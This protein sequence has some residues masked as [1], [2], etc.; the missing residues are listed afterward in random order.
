M[1]AAEPIRATVPVVIM[2][3]ET[4]TPADDALPTADAPRSQAQWS[5]SEVA[6]DLG[7]SPS[8][9]RTWIAYMSWEVTRNAEGHRVFTDEDVQ[10]LRNLKAWLDAGNSMKEF[11]RERQGEGPYDPRLELRNGVRR[12]RELQTQ[13]DAMITKHRE[14]LDGYLAARRDLQDRLEN[15]R[16]EVEVEPGAPAAAAPAVPAAPTAS[17]SEV[18]QG[19]LKQLLSALLEKQG[20]L[21]LAGRLEEGGRTYIEYAAPGGR[22]QIVEDLCATEADRKLL[23]TVLSII[24]AGHG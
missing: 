21:Q 24:L 8:L 9:V 22:K 15:L 10:Q 4:P 14:M 2:M 19:V 7:V 23:D 3:D 5:T 13:E 6:R 18:V 12:L 20:K 17:T 11:R 16:A 1:H